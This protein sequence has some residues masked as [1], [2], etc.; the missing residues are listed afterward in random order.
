MFAHTCAHTHTHTHTHTHKYTH[1]YTN[2]KPRN[3]SSV[4]RGVKVYIDGSSSFKVSI[5]L[6][7]VVF[8]DWAWE[9]GNEAVIWSVLWGCGARQQ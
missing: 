3:R 6:Y 5:T 9:S 8:P 1:K 4:L 2:R 7:L